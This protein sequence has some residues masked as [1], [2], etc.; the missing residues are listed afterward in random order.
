MPI[1]ECQSNGKPGYQWGDSGHCYTFTPGD[2][3][4]MANAHRQAEAQSAAAHASGYEDPSGTEHGNDH[5]E[6]DKRSLVGMCRKISAGARIKSTNADNYAMELINR[7]AIEHRSAEDVYTGEMHLANTQYDR[8]DERFPREY[9]DRFA[10]T[11]PGKALMPGHDYT[12]LPMGRFYDAEVRRDPQADGHYL[13][14]KFYM[15]A[16]SAHVEPIKAGVYKDSSIGFLPDKR[17]CDLCM[18][19]YDGWQQY[20]GDDTTQK[21]EGEEGG[22]NVCTHQVGQMY[23]GRK[24]TL[25]Y[26]GDAQKA[27]ALEGS[28]VWLGAQY[29]AQTMGHYP[30]H[31]TKAAFVKSLAPQ[32]GTKEKTQVDEK[33]KAAFLARQKE[34]ETETERLKPLAIDGE[35]YRTHLKAEIGRLYTSLGEKAAG[36]AV[37]K[38]LDLADA[39]AL[40]TVRSEID[41]RHAAAFA[42]GQ[43]QSGGAE[44]QKP[45]PG[46][47]ELLF[48]Q[49]GRQEVRL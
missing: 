11:L 29:G 20:H 46:M 39:A 32:A 17:I 1:R 14:A 42:Q 31:A 9:L 3:D 24:C 18:K 45:G 44:D 7:H 6:D 28:M 2:K 35:A 5:D 27:E 43:A 8:T 37:L 49:R 13:H 22:S 25:T 34:L 12:A 47:M 10:E 41:T 15:H 16:D 4:S 36:D 48:G 33:E 26:G 23:D 30:P 19:D 38:H 21:M 40:E